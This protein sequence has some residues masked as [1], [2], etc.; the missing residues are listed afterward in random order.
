M[1]REKPQA[2]IANTIVKRAELYRDRWSSFGRNTGI[3]EFSEMPSTAELRALDVF[4]EYDDGFLERIRPDVSVATWRK[5]SVLFE[6]GSYIDLAF[7]VLDGQV[8]LFLKTQAPDVVETMFERHR[9]HTIASTRVAAGSPPSEATLFQRQV[10]R[11]RPQTEGI[12]FLSVMD[13][14]LPAGG[15]ALLGAGEMFG[16][17]GAM[18]GWP[19]SATARAA[20]DCRLVQIRVPAL[21]LMRRKSSSLKERLDAVYR[22]RSLVAHLKATPLLRGADESAIHSVAQ[23]V[24][25]VSCAP[26]EVI[27]REGEP[28]DAVYLVRSGFVRLTQLVGGEPM[29]VTYLSKGMALGETEYLIDG[30]DSWTVTAASVKYAELVRISTRD[31]DELCRG[32]A[33][34]ESLLWESSVSR[35]REIGHSRRSPRESDLLEAALETGLV[36][37]NSILVIDLNRCTRCDD[38]VRGCAETHGGQ[39]RFVREGEKYQNL[40]ITKACYHCRDPVCLVGCPTGAIRRAG[41]GAVIEIDEKTCIGCSSCANNC[42]FDAIVMQPTGKNW[43]ANAL[44]EGLRGKE[45]KL[46]S[47]C[48]LCHTSSL[49]PACVRS[50]PHD[51]AVRVGSVEEF[52]R[53]LARG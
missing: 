48:D 2:E 25:L 7:L 35:I 49:G 5:G 16:E 14:D 47:K 43:P 51:C 21:R 20:T 34:T 33:A 27:V 12:T 41:V 44:P 32:N 52:K 6:E 31:L 38:C 53:L 18:S 13:V 19:Q 36:E 30:V 39:P 11:Q 45:K 17:I 10:T 22:K 3:Q 15:R 37:G 46:A 26:D 29:V 28:A 23:S 50:C 42:P 40:L 4:A 1:S 9:T 24:D 8:E